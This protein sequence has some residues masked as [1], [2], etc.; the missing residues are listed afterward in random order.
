M[1]W[2][3]RFRVQ[4][5]GFR[6]QGFGSKVYRSHCTPVAGNADDS[7]CDGERERERGGEGGRERQ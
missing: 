4:G 1:V 5:S 3:S 2:G 6:V 7:T